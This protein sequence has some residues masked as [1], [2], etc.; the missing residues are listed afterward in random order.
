MSSHAG[1]SVVDVK[2]DSIGKQSSWWFWMSGPH[3]V[4]CK[5][6]WVYQGWIKSG[7]GGGRT[8]RHCVRTRRHWQ[9]NGGWE[10]RIPCKEERT[11]RGYRNRLERV[12]GNRK[13]ENRR[14]RKTNGEFKTTLGLPK[15][16]LANMIIVLFSVLLILNYHEYSMFPEVHKSKLRYSIR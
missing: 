12:Q 13:S 3:R 2:G 7:S 4:L 1:Q 5:I 10:S 9:G 15:E 16:E 14:R 11:R 6:V 8:R